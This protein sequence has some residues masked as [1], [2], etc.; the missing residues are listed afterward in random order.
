MPP[1][2]FPCYCDGSV[3]LYCGDA[4]SMDEL[5]ADSIDLIITSP[6]Y[7]T[8]KNYR[9]KQQIGLG[10]SYEEYLLTLA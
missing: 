4:R 2:H 5:A 9:H 3:T 6:P 7:W 8:I 10:Q 1:S